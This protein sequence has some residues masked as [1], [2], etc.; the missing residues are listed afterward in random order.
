MLCPRDGT[1]LISPVES[2]K[3]VFSR[4]GIFHCPTCAGLAI[5]SEAASS[6][7]CSEKLESMH[8]GF[9]DEGTA[10]DLCCPF[11]ES[12]M[13]VR[14]TPRFS[15]IVITEVFMMGGPQR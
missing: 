7:M 10:I 12:G 1:V 15:S 6:K 3:S 13:K 2:G 8:D 11:C 9:K 5:N 4:N 14:S